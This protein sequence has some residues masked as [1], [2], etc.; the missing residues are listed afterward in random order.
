MA[1]Q[2]RRQGERQG[3]PLA[4]QGQGGEP[5]LTRRQYQDPFSAFESLFDRMQRQFFGTS[6]FNSM[7]PSGGGGGGQWGGEMQR[8][9]RVEVEDTGDSLMLSA[10]LPGLKPEEVNVECE[11]DILTIRGEK[12]QQ[13]QQGETRTE[14]YVSFFRQLQLPA[15]VDTEGAQ[16][17][18]EHG[19]LTLR[20][21]KRTQRANARQI[22][23][24]SGQ[25][26]PGGKEGQRAA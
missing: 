18:Y 21:P 17:S 1:E 9:P 19:M 6:L 8:V 15:E 5:G 7:L 14:R 12:R 13:E 20:F 25:Q 3:D 11:G 26:Q 10:E 4:R 16:A 24:G 22:P 23:I 2:N